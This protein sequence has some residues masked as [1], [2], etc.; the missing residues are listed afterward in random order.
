MLANTHSVVRLHPRPE[1]AHHSEFADLSLAVVY[2]RDLQ[3]I[4]V[5][6]DRLSGH[7][8][9][10]RRAWNLE[11]D[12]AVDPG[13][14]SVVWIGKVDFG[15]ERAGA[16]LQRVGDPGHLAGELT[17]WNFGYAHDGVNIGRH[18]ECGILRHVDKDSNHFSLHD[19][20]HER[21]GVGVALHQTTDVDVALRDDAVERRPSP[22]HSRGS[23]AAS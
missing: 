11:F 6:D 2:D 8:E 20:E 15:Q 23:D 3:S 1:V 14:Q 18:A 9:G 16:A 10:R 21:A 17:I 19:L 22:T 5:E 12:G 13:L 7:D 4:A